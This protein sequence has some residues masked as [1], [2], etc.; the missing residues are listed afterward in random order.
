MVIV[1]D[2]AHQM[3]RFLNVL[4]LSQ[5]VTLRRGPESRSQWAS[6]M[7]RVIGQIV[8]PSYS[9]GQGA[10][11]LMLK[12]WYSSIS[13]H[14]NSSSI[15]HFLYCVL[16]SLRVD[17]KCSLKLKAIPYKG[18]K[19]TT[20]KITHIT[21]GWQFG[22]V[23]FHSWNLSAAAPVQCYIKASEAIEYATAL[24]WFQRDKD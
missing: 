20:K 1:S 24:H 11:L 7:W 18:Q 15:N 17:Y 16:S 2:V 10:V 6:K 14:C 3:K 22:W 21:Y 9:R 8:C 5:A 19:K 12:C 23:R 4:D 13:A